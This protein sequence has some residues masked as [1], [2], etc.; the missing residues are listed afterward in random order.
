M[1]LAAAVVLACAAAALQAADRDTA[2]RPQVKAGDSWTYRRV[3]YDSGKPTGRLHEQVTFANERV[4]QVVGQRGRQDKDLDATYTA[5]WNFVSTATGRI[6]EPDQGLFSFPMHPGDEHDARYV[7][8]DPTVGAFEVSF[9]RHVRVVG[10]ESV[11]VPAGTFRALRVESEGPFQRRDISMA[12]TA[13]EV[14]W[15]VPEV[16][17]YV[18]WT[19]QNATFKGRGQWWGL[20]LLEYE[21]Q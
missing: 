2:P 17:R 6:Y 9:E 10:W 14:A 1:R 19:F 20:E 15:Y 11:T 3:D 7:V 5:D 4:I 16:R 21:V 13:K 18:K 8:K 12:G